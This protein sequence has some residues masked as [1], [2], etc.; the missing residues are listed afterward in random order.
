MNYNKATNILDLKHEF[1]EKELKHNYYLKA[2]QYHPDK[3]DDDHAKIHFQEILDAYNF[4]SDIDLK[5]EIENSENSEN[6]ENNYSNIL[7]KFLNG[8]L[9]KNVNKSQFIS[10]LNNKCSEITIELLDHFSK[11][12][13][14]QFH[15]FIIQYSDILH[16]NKEIVEKIELLIKNYTNNDI[17]FP[18]NPSLENLMNDEIYILNHDNETY[19]IPTWHHELVYELSQNFLVIQCQPILPEHI[20]LDQYNNLYVNLSISIKSILTEDSI[21]FNI[22]NK[23]YIIPVNELLIKKYQ[24]YTFLKQGISLINTNEIYNVCK[25]ANIYVDICFQ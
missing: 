18:L 22:G 5:R 20:T 2:L 23:N 1:T 11:N 15:N 14:L 21:T 17:V 10:I 16:I 8:I 12:T 24:R 9:N 3:N 25:R 7:E 4:L 19:Y 6:S 13:L